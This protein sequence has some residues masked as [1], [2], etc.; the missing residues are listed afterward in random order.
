MQKLIA[1]MSIWMALVSLSGCNQK[2]PE[3]QPPSA[4]KD[5]QKETLNRLLKQDSLKYT[6]PG[7]S[8]SDPKASESGGTP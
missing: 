2:E 4:E 8:P 3:P 1:S 5:Q 6:A 7:K